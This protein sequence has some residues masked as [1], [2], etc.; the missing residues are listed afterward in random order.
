MTRE[1]TNIEALLQAMSLDEKL[2]QL[3][4]IRADFGERGAELGPGKLSE[5]RAGRAGSVLDLKGAHGIH[6]GQ[7]VAAEE[8]RLR[9]PLLFTLDV[10]HGYETIFP[11]P[12][13]EAAAFDSDLWERTARAA[14]AEAAA[15]GIALTY[16]PMLDVSRDPRW[17]RIAES[18]GEDPWLGARF[19]EAKVRGFQQGGLGGSETV[20]ATAKHFAGYGAVTAGREYASADISARTLRETH[21][22]PFAAAVR[23]GVAAVMP[24]FIDIAGRPMTAHR[25]MLQGVLRGALGFSGVTISDFFA[26]RELIAH[27][28]AADA[29]EAAALALNAGVDIDMAS[30]AYL[31]GLPEALSRGLVALE[32]IDAA[33]RRVLEL[34]VRLGLFEAPFARGGGPLS[35]ARRG[36]HRALA[37]EAARKSIVLLK[38]RNAILPLGGAGRLAI[39]GPMADAPADMLGCWRASGKPED[40]I[41][42]LNGLRSALS[43]WRVDDGAGAIGDADVILLCVGESASMCGEATSRARPSLPEEQRKL[44]EEVFSVGKPVIVALTSGRPLIDPW[45][46]EN[47]G[48][49]LASWFLGSEA[50]AALADVLSGAHNPGGKLPISWPYDVGQI[51]IAY[52]ERPTGRPAKADEHDTSKYLDVPVG[53]QFPFGHG[54]SYS[55]FVYGEP[56][57]SPDV[58]RAGGRIVVEA[59]ITNEGPASGEETALLFIRDPVASISRPVLELKGL[60]AIS[61]AAEQSGTVRFE[62]GAD[63]LAFHGEDGAPRLE[64]GLIEIFVGSNADRASLKACRLHVAAD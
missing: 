11:I 59:E 63:D 29:V 38:N 36:E 20:A 52:A 14:A 5:I 23:A 21:L 25:D 18:P 41:S 44:A 57:V 9:I 10:L 61:L 56:S 27:G 17:G 64:P 48:A 3:T 2:G 28:V 47:A 33:V 24:A 62:L 43:G 13:A 37:R 30:G 35:D 8:S 31:E 51:P 53:P 45:L 32:T 55:R 4:M 58:V 6:A 19:A 7:K 15:D 39:V 26:V 1:I 50:G 40:T 22:P 60:A 16:A 12:L 42:F 46:I 54:L 34:K 49:V